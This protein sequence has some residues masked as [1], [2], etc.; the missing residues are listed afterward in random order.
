[1]ILLF[2]NSNKLVCKKKQFLLPAID[3]RSLCKN[4]LSKS[5]YT[6][7]VIQM[8]SIIPLRCIGIK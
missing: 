4:T 5:R 1:M 8:K 2:M 6:A 7:L 3:F